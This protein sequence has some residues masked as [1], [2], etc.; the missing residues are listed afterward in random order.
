[1][2]RVESHGKG[3]ARPI[4]AADSPVPK[5][6]S[7]KSTE[8]DLADQG[9]H[10]YGDAGTRSLAG[11]SRFAARETWNRQ[12][13]GCLARPGAA[14]PYPGRR[15]E[16]DSPAPAHRGTAHPHGI[17]IR[18]GLNGQWHQGGGSPTGPR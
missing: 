1:M 4:S 12:V 5:A 9:A 11:R 6:G 16:L 3:F 14:R 10:V 13:R 18:C 17:S 2:T 15:P 8:P 7:D